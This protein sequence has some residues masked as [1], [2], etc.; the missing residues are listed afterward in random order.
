MKN[1]KG[2]TALA[3]ILIVVIVLVAA[4]GIWY[5]ETTHKGGATNPVAERNI[6]NASSA[7]QTTGSSTLVSSSSLIAAISST[8]T[9]EAL[10]S[11]VPVETQSI[12]WKGNGLIGLVPTSTTF[13]DANGW[14]TEVKGAD[15][16]DMV[17]SEVT[18]NIPPCD[19]NTDDC[20]G[21]RN[22]P[23]IKFT[24]EI[25]TTDQIDGTPAGDRWGNTYS[26]LKESQDN[27]GG[28]SQDFTLIP[29]SNGSNGKIIIL[30]HYSRAFC[31]DASTEDDYKIIIAD[32]TMMT[33]KVYN[34]NDLAAALPQ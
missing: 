14:A 19:S 21:A 28:L 32:I 22:N 31:C 29:N 7:A 15:S 34:L 33:T 25:V 5:F 23:T 9:I 30:A 13:G 18:D 20:Y 10:A 27:G 3:I 1:I 26:I 2:F 24:N 12:L 6:Q 8:S 17:I 4:G 16:F 11:A